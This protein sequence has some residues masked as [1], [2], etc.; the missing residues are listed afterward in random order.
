M[1]FD[2]RIIAD[3]KIQEAIEEGLF[4][5]LPGKGQPLD[6]DDDPATPAHLRL[7]NRILKNANVLPDWVQIDVDIRKTREEC[8]A[9]FDRVGREYERRRTGHSGRQFSEWHSRSRAAYV[10]AMKAVNTDILKLN[11]AAPRTAGVQIPFRIEEETARFDAAFPPPADADLSWKPTEERVERKLR[12]LA[13]ED[14][15]AAKNVG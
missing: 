4:D 2:T 6:L 1:S 8:K 15:R 12:A 9:V 14:Y 11:M 7:A 5:D 10:R 3:R 13:A